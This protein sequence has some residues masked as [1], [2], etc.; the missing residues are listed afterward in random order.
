LYILDIVDHF[1][2]RWWMLFVWVLEWL[3]FLYLGK[4]L[5]DFI[6]SHSK[7]KNFIFNTKIYYYIS[8]L[9]SVVVLGYL[10]TSQF[11]SEG[12][13]Y[14]TYP[15]SYIKV[16]GIWVVIGL[17]ILSVVINLLDILKD[18]KDE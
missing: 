11:I 5:I 8:W 15:L 6:I 16:Y 9:F 7:C 14:W 18:N 3:V 4:K 17:L 1:I 10:L 12:I 2:T 13:K